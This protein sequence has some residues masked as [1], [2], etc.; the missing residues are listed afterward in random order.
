MMAN[1]YNEPRFIPEKLHQALHSLLTILP[2]IS[3]AMEERFANVP[4]PFDPTANSNTMTQL[5]PGSN[6]QQQL[7]GQFMTSIPPFYETETPLGEC[8]EHTRDFVVPTAAV[9]TTK[10]W[11]MQPN[12]NGNGDD[13]NGNQSDHYSLHCDH[14]HDHVNVFNMST[15]AEHIEIHEST[16]TNGNMN[17]NNGGFHN[18]DNNDNNDSNDQTRTAT[19]QL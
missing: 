19:M 10:E 8:T 1:Y 14:D 5:P 9:F 18:G 4:A 11:E 7:S 12:G 16:S 3:V 6:P 13:V 15:V 2:E 17:H